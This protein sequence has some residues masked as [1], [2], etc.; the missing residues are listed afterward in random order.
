[1]STKSCSLL[2]GIPDTSF[3]TYIFDLGC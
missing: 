1:M 2:T 3:Q